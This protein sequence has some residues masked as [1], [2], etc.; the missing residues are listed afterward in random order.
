MKNKDEHI[1]Q[2]KLFQFLR[3]L[4]AQYPALQFVFAIP[5][6]SYGGGRYAMLRGKYF[7]AEGRKRGVP[8]IFVPIPSKGYHGLFIEMKKPKH[9]KPSI[10][11]E[12]KQYLKFLNK[13]GYKAIVCYGFEHA[14]QVICDYLDLDC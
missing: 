3:L 1:E 13:Q 12:Q 6:E 8:D 11:K 9:L 14:K 10:S 2:V 5:N 7:K 4:S